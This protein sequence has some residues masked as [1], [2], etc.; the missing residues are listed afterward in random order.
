MNSLEAENEAREN[1]EGGV[2]FYPLHMMKEIMVAL[3]VVIVIFAL[4]T[5][6]PAGLEEAADGF[7]TPEH[8]K[9]EWYFLSL[10]QALKYV[11]N[12]NLL[13]GFTYLNLAVAVQGLF[14]ATLI[15]LPF[16]DKYPNKAIRK[17][18]LF[19][20]LGIGAIIFM[21]VFTYLGFYSG[22]EDPIFGIRIH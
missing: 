9:P 3:G 4:S 12:G 15:A 5:I 21:L 14:F 2:P 10:Y 16:V 7:K 17:R 18:P 13:G 11:P 8:V 19:L 22:G 6:H 1:G 20:L